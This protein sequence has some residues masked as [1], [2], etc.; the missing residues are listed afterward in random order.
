MSQ[1]KI[2]EYRSK[3]I[4]YDLLGVKYNGICIDISVSNW[5]EQVVDLDPDMLYVVKID[6]AIKKRNKLGLIKISRT[7]NQII[8]DIERYMVDGFVYYI[9]EPLVK[10]SKSD[11]MYLSLIRNDV[12]VLINY[13]EKGGIDIEHNPESIITFI[14]KSDTYVDIP[15]IGGGINKFISVVYG[16]FQDSYMSF[17]EIN[18]LVSIEGTMIP[19]DAAIVVDGAAKFFT[20]TWNESDYRVPNSAAC[21]QERLIEILASS[22]SS[23]FNFKPLNR[24]GSVFVLLSGGGASVVIADEISSLGKYELLGNY[25]EYS[26]NPTEDETYQYTK[27]VIEYMIE[28]KSTS[29]R[30]IIAGGVA[31]FTDISTTFIG[32]IR[33]LQEKVNIIKA[34]NIRIYVRRGGP[35]QTS[36]LK[37]ISD[38]MS[39]NDIG[40]SVS[41]P[42]VTISE[43]II[44]A[45]KG[46]E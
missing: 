39:V 36:G 35:N 4:I 9:V 31:N 20:D 34:Q 18:P 46:L 10:H 8:K 3:N 21:E 38:F 30:L 17:C 44:Q 37:L 11:E 32:M 26:G 33:A 41:G 15:D 23:S 28:S 25:G 27:Q 14:Q 29:K 7:T 45:L 6:Q 42:E 19:L 5:R 40:G 12:G 16:L 2:S 43:K 13:S 1:H 22:S 24:D